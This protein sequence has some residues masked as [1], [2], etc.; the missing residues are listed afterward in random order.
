MTLPFAAKSRAI[1]GSVGLCNS[2]GFG[3]KNQ[4]LIIKSA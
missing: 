1:N 3:G 2:F 4:V